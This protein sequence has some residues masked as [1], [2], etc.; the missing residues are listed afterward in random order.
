MA[1]LSLHAISQLPARR[2]QSS[3]MHL[4]AAQ[5]SVSSCSA[6]VF[7][8]RCPQPNGSTV[9]ALRMRSAEKSLP[10]ITCLA[11]APTT[12]IPTVADT[13][14]NFLES[15]RRPVP[16]IYNN[17]IQ[18]LLVQHHLLRYNTTYQYDAVF[19]LG[20]VTVYDQLMDGY[21]SAEDRDAIFKA[22]VAALKED[23]EQYRADAKK[24]EGWASQQNSTSIISFAGEGEV[25]AILKDITERAAGKGS[26]HYSRFFAIGLFRLLEVAKASDPAVLEQLANALN[27]NKLSIDRDLDVY[28]NLLN[29]LTQAKEL[30]KEYVEREKKKA[31]ERETA[32]AKKSE[33]V[34][35]TEAKSE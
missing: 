18:E 16:S 27:V 10:A 2:E 9:P 23:P 30:L 15:Y 21:P 1:S 33:E 13:K 4:M 34:A 14:R 6:L 24:L 35:K 29:K 31:A 5:G 17:V 25:E 32:A 20:F 11:A 22:Y 28:R 7:A 8:L 12:D 3:S 19:A 26:F